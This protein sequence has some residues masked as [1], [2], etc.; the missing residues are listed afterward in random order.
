MK[1]SS[2]VDANGKRARSTSLCY[3]PADLQLDCL[4]VAHMATQLMSTFKPAHATFGAAASG[5]RARENVELLVAKGAFDD[6][7]RFDVSWDISDGA[8][9]LRATLGLTEE[10]SGTTKRVYHVSAL[11]L[12]NSWSC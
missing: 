9:I 4:I 12:T 6:Q 11:I 2:V 8:R 5:R 10:A 1:D 7:Q 3:R